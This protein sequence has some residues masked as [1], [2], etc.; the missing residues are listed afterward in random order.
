MR[1]ESS[2]A[3]RFRLSRACGA[4]G[5]RISRHPGGALSSSPAASPALPGKSD[6]VWP[7]SPMPSTTASKGR[8]IAPIASQAWPAPDAG[9]A[10]AFFRP[11]KRAWAAIPRSS[12]A[13]SRPS[14]L[15]GSS[16]S[17]QRSSARVI[18]TRAQSSPWCARWANISVGLRPPETTRLA[19]AR[20]TRAA[21]RS[22]AM[23][24]ASVAACAVGSLSR[25]SRS[26]DCGS[27][28]GFIAPGIAVAPDHR[29]GGGGPPAAGRVGLGRV[30][31]VRPAGTD[32]IDPAPGGIELVAA[33]EQGEVALD[34]I[35]QQSFIGRQRP[36]LE[37]LG[38]IERQV[39][40]TQPHGIAR[41]FGEHR[42]RD[43]LVGLQLDY[44]LVGRILRAIRK[45]RQRH[46]I[47]GNG[48]LGELLLQ[49]LAGTQVEGDAGPA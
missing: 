10:A 8:G 12:V 32:R 11:R 47:E 26:S 22:A 15:A 4:T 19:P 43:A 14:L 44:E 2:S 21:R 7:S 39:H 5:E 34:D 41:R 16:L 45:D 25:H 18:R 36:L 6:A 46:V 17:T 29:G 48:Y 28:S 23:A 3:A 49:A 24:A 27:G 1:R 42:E 35:H 33:H 40:G 38:Q 37:A 31:G 30:A 9:V 13:R 20:R